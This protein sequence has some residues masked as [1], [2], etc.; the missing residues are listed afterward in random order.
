MILD[1]QSKKFNDFAPDSFITQKQLLSLLNRQPHFK[2]ELVNLFQIDEDKTEV[3]QI[4]NS[5][6]LIES[7]LFL[8]SQCEKIDINS[9]VKDVQLKKMLKDEK[10]IF[11]IFKITDTEI[12]KKNKSDLLEV[13]TAYS[14]KQDML[15]YYSFSKFAN[16]LRDKESEDLIDVIKKYLNQK[17]ADNPDSKSLRLLYKKSEDKFYLRTVT[18]VDNYQDF[19]LNFSVFVALI[20]LSRYV[21]ESQSKIYIDNYVA[22]D[23]NLYVSFSLSDG[24]PINKNLSINFNLILENDEIKRNA[25]SFNGVFKLTYNDGK[26]NSEI[27]IKPKGVKKEDVAFPVDLL[28]YK[29]TGNTKS[30]FDKIKDLPDLID[31]FITQV[32]EDAK[33]ISEIKNPKDV[34]LHLAKKIKYSKKAEFKKYKDSVFNKLMKITVDNTF[35]LF[36]IFREID[37]LFENED[38]ISRDYWREKLYESLI[39]KK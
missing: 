5:K 3:L 32:S 23:S 11:E 22:D 34:R 12:I 13:E 18:S 38:V 27:Y 35:N 19:G 15:D 10:A 26:K 29:H 37:E 6:F 30:V 7:L 2:E 17:N 28:T 24:K 36:E 31:F 1:R 39:E 16:Y 8:D 9:K 4:G 25:V 14:A 33:N 21:T 20:A